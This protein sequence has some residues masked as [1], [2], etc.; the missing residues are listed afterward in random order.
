LN[1]EAEN[2]HLNAQ[3]EMVRVAYEMAEE[4]TTGAEQ[5]ISR[6]NLSGEHKAKARDLAKIMLN[7]AQKAEE[8]ATMEYDSLIASMSDA[9]IGKPGIANPNKFHE[10]I[11][12]NLDKPVPERVNR[13][14][15]AQGDSALIK[16][17][18]ERDQERARELAELK[19]Q[20]NERSEIT[21]GS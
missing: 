19:Q 15:Q 18:L 1:I 13:M 11:C 7:G 10:W 3:I 17:L 21:T 9:Q 2:S 5:R 12:L 14:P 6:S 8:R 4:F 20:I 16:A